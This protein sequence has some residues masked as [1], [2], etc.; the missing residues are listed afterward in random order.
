MSEATVNVGGKHVGHGPDDGFPEGGNVALQWL[1]VNGRQLAPVNPVQ[2]VDQVHEGA[3]VPK[4]LHK[5]MQAEV[6]N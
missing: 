5:F 1:L 6:N 3:K 2:R 4:E